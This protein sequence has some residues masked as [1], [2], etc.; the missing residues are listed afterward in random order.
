[1]L[2]VALSLLLVG[3]F[4]LQFDVQVLKDAIVE[5]SLKNNG[6]ESLTMLVW[7]TPFDDMSTVFRAPIFD[8]EHAS[9]VSAIYSGIMIKRFPIISDFVTI[10]PGQSLVTVLDLHKG[11]NFPLAGVY[12][13]SLSSVARI[14]RGEI[15]VAESLKESLEQFRHVCLHSETFA[16]EV[17]E[18][19]APLVWNTTQ[20]E[21]ERLGAVTPV[22]CSGADLTRVQTADN[23]AASMLSGA[24]SN[25]GTACST[26]YKRWFG[27]CPNSANVDHVKKVISNTISRRSAGYRGDCSRSGCSGNVYAFVYPADTTY[28]VHLCSSFFSTSTSSCVYDCT[29]G[30]MIHELTHFNSV[31]GTKDYAYGTSA[32][33]NL[34][35]SN[36]TQ[37]INN[38]DNYEYFNENCSG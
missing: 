28:T 18:A 31:G 33:Q 24:N 27:V 6:S 1:M 20:P 37:A 17:S 12:K 7:N 26:R 11:Y 8:V 15:D 34:A 14:A 32:C 13:V 16:I 19:S 9:G 29:G 23:N 3:S 4:A 38:A 30:V 5:V 2:L 35:T 25:L 10:R 36:P 22:S 21:G